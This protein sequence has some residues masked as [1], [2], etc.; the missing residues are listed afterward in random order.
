[1]DHTAVNACT[2]VKFVELLLIREHYPFGRLEISSKLERVK[3]KTSAQFN[4]NLLLKMRKEGI[5]KEGKE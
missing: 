3:T 5:K 2:L 1:M 4:F